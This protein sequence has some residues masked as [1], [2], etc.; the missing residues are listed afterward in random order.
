M[1]QLRLVAKPLLLA[2]L[3]ALL[4]AC[5]GLPGAGSD[6]ERCWPSFPYR[7]GWLGG[8]AAYSIPL[9][10]SETLW[11]FGDTFVG[12]PG[13]EDRQGAAFVHNS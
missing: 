12:A 9:S 3:A 11:L 7:D 10:R 5:A 4:A 13:Q 2:C 1:R 6:P 8:D